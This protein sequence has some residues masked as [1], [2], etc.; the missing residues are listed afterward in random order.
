MDISSVSNASSSR[1]VTPSTGSGDRHTYD[2]SQAK[3]AENKAQER[4][5]EHRAVQENLQR[6]KDQNQRR[7]EGRIVSYGQ[8]QDNISSQD[9]RATLN[10]TRVNEAYTPPPRTESEASQKE[11]AQRT[12]DRN[13]E[14]IDIVV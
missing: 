10:R 7:L 3:I 11:Q 6:N 5:L 8:E 14:A 9:K 2:D 12:H 1:S 4:S 13:P